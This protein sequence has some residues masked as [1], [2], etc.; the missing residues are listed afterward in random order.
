H[1]YCV[2]LYVTDPNGLN[3]EFTVDHPAAD[4]IKAKRRASAREDLDK[5]LRGDRTTN[6]E[7]RDEAKS[8][9]RS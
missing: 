5:W 2:S 4:S 9:P 7:W 3:L 6:N 8:A 1:G